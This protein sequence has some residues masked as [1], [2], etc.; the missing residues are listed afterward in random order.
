MDRKP[1]KLAGRNSAARRLIFQYP[2]GLILPRASPH[3]NDGSLASIHRA[4]TSED[5]GRA[6]SD[7]GRGRPQHAAAQRGSQAETSA[8]DQKRSA[9]AGRLSI[10]AAGTKQQVQPA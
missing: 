1:R 7:A 9:V 5:K 3:S 4:G 10:G 6:A 2:W 8:E